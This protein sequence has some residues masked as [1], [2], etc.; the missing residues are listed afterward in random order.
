[1]NDLN[2]Y[3]LDTTQW[4]G[5]IHRIPISGDCNHH[6][7]PLS[8]TSNVVCE[9]RLQHINYIRYIN[10]MDTC[11]THGQFTVRINHMSFQFQMRC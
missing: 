4:L 1:M 5:S 11:S 10:I 7:R 9:I 8:D 6:F 2:S 3:D